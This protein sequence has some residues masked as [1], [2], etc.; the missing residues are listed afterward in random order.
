MAF[1]ACEAHPCLLYA[2]KCY[3]AAP[4]PAARTVNK[5][6]SLRDNL[7]LHALILHRFEL[8]QI[9]AADG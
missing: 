8:T 2:V 5:I 4:R 6:F 7:F 3:S 9:E 1:Y